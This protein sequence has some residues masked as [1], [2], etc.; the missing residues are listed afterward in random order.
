MLQTT[1]QINFSNKC[2]KKCYNNEYYYLSIICSQYLTRAFQ[3][4]NPPHDIVTSPSASTDMKQ[5]FQSRFLQVVAS[6][7]SSGI[8][9]PA[10]YG[11]TIKSQ[12]ARAVAASKSL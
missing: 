11:T 10:K 5:T 2:D 7:L 12:H 1:F 6:H 4:T 8:L 9:P 3:A